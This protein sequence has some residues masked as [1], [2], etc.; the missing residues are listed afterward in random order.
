M[1]KFH[2][3]PLAV[4][5]LGFYLTAPVARAWTT[6]L[7]VPLE[8]EWRLEPITGETKA[9]SFEIVTGKKS[10]LKVSYVFANVDP[11]SSK[12]PDEKG[13]DRFRI[14]SDGEWDLSD[15]SWCEF[16]V[17]GD[18]SPFATG[19]TLIDENGRYIAYQRVPIVDPRERTYG[20]TL[21]GPGE[22]I[23]EFDF[24][25]VKQI[26]IHANEAGEH[27]YTINKGSFLI[28]AITFSHKDRESQ[29]KKNIDLVEAIAKDDTGLLASVAKLRQHLKTRSGS[30]E[31]LEEESS[32]LKQAAL[33][34]QGQAGR[35][36]VV[37]DASTMDR[38]RPRLL[39]FSGLPS[40][41]LTLWAAA[42][43]YESAQLVVVPQVGGVQGV[44][45]SVNQDLIAEDGSRISRD[46][47]VVRKADFVP[48]TP[49]VY[50]F[51]D[52]VGEVAD[53]LVPNSIFNIAG[54]RIQPVWV[55][56][57]VP[58]N[59]KPGL[60]ETTVR[61]S[62]AGR[63]QEIPLKLNVFGFALPKTSVVARHVYYW[64]P[65][66]ANW[67]GFRKEAE[68]CG[69]NNDGYDIPINLIKEHLAFLLEYRLDVV[70]ITW[71]FSTEDG[72]PCWPLK[73]KGD[74]SLDFTLHD[75]LL[76]FC[77]ERGMK[78]FS[79]GDF[80]R[81]AERIFDPTYQENVRRVMVP[82]IA[83]LK[84]K[85][86]LDKGIFK[87]YDEPDTDEGY[88]A[89]MEECRLVRSLDPSI[90]TL[91]AIAQ[92]RDGMKDLLNIWLVRP[93]NWS[94]EQIDSIREDGN[95]GSWYWCSVPCFKP[96]PNYF[97][98]YPASD[99]RLIEW[100]H[101]KYECTYSLYWAVNNWNKN[102]KPQGQPRWPDVTW[103]SNTYATFNG[104]GLLVYP[105]PDG[106]FAASVRLESL[107]DGAEDVEYFALLSDKLERLARVQPDS[108]LIK[109]GRAILT[110]TPVV[111]S[112]IS[113]DAD[114]KKM[115]DVRLAAAAMIEKIDRRLS[116]GDVAQA[117]L[118]PPKK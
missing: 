47:I 74:G 70:N 76:A 7:S 82:Y 91:A 85:G 49:S 67:Y 43:E 12:Y 13:A 46:N 81:S 44:A 95:V 41:G 84:G 18:G 65:A 71:P 97:T 27:R 38:L 33:F 2:L 60:Y 79:V 106:S 63:M 42:N 111:E 109:E 22:K 83:H 28:S 36:F 118:H 103:N 112:I 16:Q 75:E 19:V 92:P 8:G 52:Y 86:W 78:N 26:A 11:N 10:G 113:Y 31:T 20:F 101:Y 117:R 53:V 23:P 73:V 32:R 55:T 88:N 57:H 39:N 66:V 110:L 72:K 93:N 15:F 77:F 68:A 14:V 99:P 64:L 61:V 45:V 100:M 48:T 96:F 114:A 34:S 21:E 80:G 104:D 102:F 17:T 56:I 40:K 50:T 90:K 5:L 94:Q 25:K 9:S 30:L 98:N 62:G 59:V 37:C 54:D 107:R 69:Y 24:S 6:S 1:K 35:P 116:S 51:V 4:L 87:V 108:A 89:L 115:N 105:W 3:L 58:E 29:I